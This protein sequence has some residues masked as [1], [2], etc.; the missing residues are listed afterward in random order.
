MRHSAAAPRSLEPALLV[1]RV[2]NHA[3]QL[4]TQLGIQGRH[5]CGHSVAPGRHGL[6]GRL[7]GYLQAGRGWV[8]GQGGPSRSTA[9]GHQEHLRTAQQEMQ[10]GQGP[11]LT[12][13]SPR[14]PPH[15]LGCRHRL[16]PGPS[17]H[18][19]LLLLLL[20]G[21]AC[22]LAQRGPCQPGVERQRAVHSQ[23]LAPLRAR[24]ARAG[25]RTAIVLVQRVL[26][27]PIVALKPAAV[28]L[29]RRP[30]GHGAAA[31]LP[32]CRRRQLA[33]VLIAA[34]GRGDWQGSL[35]A[36]ACCL[37]SYPGAPGE[38]APGTPL[39]GPG[40]AG[41]ACCWRKHMLVPPRPEDAQRLRT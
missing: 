27:L 39:R 35:F 24:H 13:K 23:A 15:L 12:S 5:L 22:C 7:S 3:V 20:L 8:G 31:A 25:G 26:Q 16:A 30:R 32:R 29:L 28:A 1:G 17:G 37:Q 21:V 2:L 40:Q 4:G 14:A 19:S 34:A 11:S 6:G 36:F 18:L 9:R 33:R 38:H 10:A 41:T